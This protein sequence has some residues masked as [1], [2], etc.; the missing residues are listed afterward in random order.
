MTAELLKLPSGRFLSYIITGS[1]S[2]NAIPFVYFHGNPSGYPLMQSLVSKCRE[3]KL[4][5]VS[6]SRA[7]YGDSSRD[8]GRKVVDIVDD[9]RALVDYIGAKEFFVGGWSGGGELS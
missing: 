7:G 5:L 2:P 1:S 3:A 8:K 4:K 6:F 9:V